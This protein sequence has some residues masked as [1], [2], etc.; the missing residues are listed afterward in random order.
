MLSRHLIVERAGYEAYSHIMSNEPIF[1]MCFQEVAMVRARM[2]LSIATLIALAVMV[3]TLS[4]P[5]AAQA[6]GVSC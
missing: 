3:A 4:S 1:G 6:G 5:T 2:S